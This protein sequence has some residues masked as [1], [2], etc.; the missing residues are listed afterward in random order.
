[1]EQ[2]V[3]I[4]TLTPEGYNLKDKVYRLA[5]SP[6]GQQLAKE[7]QDVLTVLQDNVVPL[8]NG[9]YI[10]NSQIPAIQKEVDEVVED[11]KPL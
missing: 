5:E 3:G 11:V 7:I 6:K 9:L 4:W 2:A 10:D 8:E 1:M